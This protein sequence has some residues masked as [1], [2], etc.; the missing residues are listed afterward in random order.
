MLIN[1]TGAHDGFYSAARALGLV[2]RQ[3]SYLDL[4]LQL[5]NSQLIL[6]T[7]RI[8]REGIEIRMLKDYSMLNVVRRLDFS[9][10]FF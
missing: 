8:K 2:R 9:F 10:L 4:D 6:H 5:S 1:W 3:L 7:L